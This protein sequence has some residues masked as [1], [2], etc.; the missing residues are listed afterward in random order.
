MQEAK[1][2][3]SEKKAQPKKGKKAKKAQL[4]LLLVWTLDGVMKQRG[5]KE[6]D[7]S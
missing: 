5:D 1:C 3:D 4:F 6:I 2:K 7:A